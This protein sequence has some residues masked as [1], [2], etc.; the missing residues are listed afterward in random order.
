VVDPVGYIIDKFDLRNASQPWMPVLIPNSSRKDLAGLFAELGFRKGAEIG[1]GRGSYA[2]VL[3]RH[4]PKCRIYCIDPWETYDELKDWPDQNVLNEYWISA[5]Q[6]LGKFPEVRIIRKY[7]MDA[8]SDFPDNSL[9]FVFID[10]NHS[11]PY[12]AEDIF[13]WEKKVR[14]GGIV[15][16][17]DYL[18]VPRKDVVVQVREVV[19]AYTEAFKIKKWFVVDECSLKRCGSFFWV[20]Q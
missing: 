9:D 4:N 14:P 15:S 17:H 5:Q 2:I 20:K 18:K 6:R 16:G 8:L 19:D 7:S 1:T 12:V 3:A 13:Y 11:F 10:G